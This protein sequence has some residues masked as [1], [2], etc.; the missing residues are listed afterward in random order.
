RDPGPHQIHGDHVRKP[1][2]PLRGD[3]PR[4]RGH[5]PQPG[6]LREP[7]G[8]GR[9]PGPDR[10]RVSRAADRRAR[11]D[12]PGGGLPGQRRRRRHERHP[13]PRG[14]RDPEPALRPV[15]GLSVKI[16]DLRAT[17]VTV[18]AEAPWRW[19]MGIETGTTRTIIELITDEG[20]VGLGETY[21]GVRTVEALEIAKPFLVGL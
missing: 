12:R 6:V 14:R 1:G 21:G 3:L 8:S 2:H 13:R 16:V 10:A 4:R 5:G 19:S 17:P 20:I 15:R 18:P 11:R 9:V 7:T